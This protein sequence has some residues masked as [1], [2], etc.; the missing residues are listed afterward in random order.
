MRLFFKIQGSASH[1]AFHL[2]RLGCE[3]PGRRLAEAGP[4]S[5][6][7]VAAL[8]KPKSRPPSTQLSLWRVFLCAWS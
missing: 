3:D 2:T 5:R 1:W 4:R 6:E 8:G 7:G